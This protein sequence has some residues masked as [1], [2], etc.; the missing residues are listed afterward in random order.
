MSKLHEQVRAAVR[1]VVI[2]GGA[3]GATA[4]SR[5]KRLAPESEVILVEETAMISH[6]PCGIPY[7]LSGVASP[8]EL[9]AYDP[10]TFERERG[11]R[12]LTN[13][14]A[15]EIDLDKRAVR[16]RMGERVESLAY[17]KLIIATGSRPIKPKIEG[18][19]L[20][21]VETVRHPYAVKDLIDK[22]KRATTVAIVGGGYIG[23][24]VAD[25]LVRAGKRVVLIE[26]LP[27]LMGRALDRDVAEIL[28]EEVRR[29]GVDVRLGESIAEIERRGGRLIV[30]TDKGSYESD[31]VLLALG[32]RPNSELA[33]RAGIPLGE[34]GAVR[35]NSFMETAA[36]DVYAAGDVAEKTH[37]LLKAK[38]WIPLATT[39]NKE[40]YV[41]GTNAAGRKR[42]EFP[43]VVGT[44]ITKYGDLYIGRTGLSEEEAAAH[45]MKTKSKIVRVYSKAHYYPGGRPVYVKLIARET[46]GVVVGGQVAGYTEMVAGYLD[47]LA[48]AVDRALTAEDLFFSDL[49][50]MPAV[51]PVW[52]PL[53]TAARV[54]LKE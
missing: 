30:H 50:Y 23:V 24:E 14:R 34:S 54:L 2:G 6:A 35:V 38:V 9:A 41:A 28:T 13:T 8:E 43:G 31:L 12:V 36:P 29:S 48:I 17:D 7:A 49:G 40:G 21:G 3:A 1:V 22:V 47:A 26:K 39:A 46:D 51:A 37:K 20:P 5:A 16:V 52:H 10:Q 53:V 25:N 19:D 45:G 11:V 32:V 42:V 27:A 4:A 44:A 33:A 18:A 15:E